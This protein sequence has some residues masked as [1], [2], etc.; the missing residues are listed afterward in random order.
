MRPAGGAFVLVTLANGARSIRSLAH[1]ETFHPV[2][3]PEAEA[4]ALYLHNLRIPERFAAQQ[5]PF[6]IWDVG[7][8][9]AAN[10]LTILRATRQ[11]PGSLRILSFDLTDEP[12]RFALQHAAELP[13]LSGSVAHLQR[14]LAQGEVDWSQSTVRWSLHLGDFPALLNSA[15]VTDWP[16]PHAILF[17]PF[18]PARNPAMWTLPLFRRLFQVCTR[19]CALATYSRSTMLRVTMLLAGFYVGA[20]QATG[21][22]EETTLAANRPELISTPLDSAW[23]RRV[24]HSTSAEPMSEPVYRQA[25]LSAAFWDQLVDHPQFAVP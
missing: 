23:L 22:K 18:S 20:G 10:P 16:A 5:G 17:D 15:A 14:M 8:G 7:L 25:R 2:I 12:L 11:L 13:Y 24:R 21:E 3:G 9:G 19:P 6:V 1:G 4:E